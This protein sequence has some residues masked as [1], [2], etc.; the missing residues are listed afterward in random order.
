MPQVITLA[1]AL[2]PQVL[3]RCF[4]LIRRKLRQAATQGYAKSTELA[5]SCWFFLRLL[6]DPRSLRPSLAIEGFEKE[7]PQAVPSA[8]PPAPDCLFL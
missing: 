2:I 3:G 1:W 5:R 8:L 7:Q 4:S 6:I